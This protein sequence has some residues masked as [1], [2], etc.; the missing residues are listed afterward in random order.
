M[1]CRLAVLLCWAVKRSLELLTSF[2]FVHRLGLVGGITRVKVPV[3][4]LR[5]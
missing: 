2:I 5:N 1:L 4:P 3:L